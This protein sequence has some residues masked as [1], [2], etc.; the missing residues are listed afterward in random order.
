MGAVNGN[1]DPTIR[2][3][4]PLTDRETYRSDLVERLATLRR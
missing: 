2:T 4:G 3:D 1:T